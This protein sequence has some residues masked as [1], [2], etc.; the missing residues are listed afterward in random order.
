MESAQVL[1]V[2]PVLA[3]FIRHPQSVDGASERYRPLV[4]GPGAAALG[5]RERRRLSMEGRSPEL[6]YG[7]D[8]V[9]I[10]APRRCVEGL[11]GRLLVPY[12]ELRRRH[13]GAVLLERRNAQ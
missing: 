5:G 4:H 7:H 9:R 1:E 6:G 8:R 3:I 12:D 13:E 11:P 10:R 2:P